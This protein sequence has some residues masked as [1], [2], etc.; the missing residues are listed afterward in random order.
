M[1]NAVYIALY[2][3]LILN[4]LEVVPGPSI[5]R[6]DL[7]QAYAQGTHRAHKTPW[8]KPQE[9]PEIRAPEAPKTGDKPETS[10]R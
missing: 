8:R 7:R 3:C 2:V 9:T 10:E 4:D 6:I 1:S 5:L